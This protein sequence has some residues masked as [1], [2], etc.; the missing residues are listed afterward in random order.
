MILVDTTGL[1]FQMMHACVGSC[2]LSIGDDGLYD[3]NIISKYVVNALAE[4]V[5]DYAY[6]F[7]RFGRVVLCCDDL[8]EGNWRRDIYKSYKKSRSKTVN[9]LPVGAVFN[10]VNSLL[11]QFNVCTCVSVVKTC[12]AEADDC[13][14]VLAE[15]FPGEKS[16]IISSDKDMLQAQVNPN[17]SQYSP[18]TKKMITYKDKGVNSLS[19]WVMLHVILGDVT[20]D[21]PRIFDCTEYTSEFLGFLNESGLSS[22]VKDYNEDVGVAFY[23]SHPDSDVW[24][25]HK[26]GPK[27]V[28]K[29]INNNT[30]NDFIIKYRDNY[31]RNRKLVLSEGIPQYVRDGVLESYNKSNS[32]NKLG[33]GKFMDYLDVNDIKH[34]ANIDLLGYKETVSIDDFL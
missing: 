1:V 19:E 22:D 33:I 8:R 6:R 21:V 32:L 24:V 9:P 2:K 23:E 3:A 17:I 7:G 29:M 27:T 18:M 25:K 34:P 30:I 20:D 26:I 12:K 13:I 14:L 4:S 31:E 16:I 28:Q 10:E 15:S 11:D 5:V